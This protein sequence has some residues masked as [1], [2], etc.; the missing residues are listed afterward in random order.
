MRSLNRDLYSK[1]EE[2]GLFCYIYLSASSK[3]DL[4]WLLDNIK[5]L[6][7]HDMIQGEESHVV[8]LFLAGDAS[9]EGGYLGDLTNNKTLLSLPFS[10]EEEIESSTMRELN[11]FYKYYMKNNLSHL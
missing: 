3:R 6:N 8:D 9:G 1:V 2:R 11:V 7:G 10:P 5:F 4:K